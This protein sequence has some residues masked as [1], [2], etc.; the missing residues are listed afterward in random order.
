VLDLDQVT[1]ADLLPKAT[2][3]LHLAGD[4]VV[5]D[6][7]LEH[8]QPYRPRASGGPPGQTTMT[9]L[10]LTGVF[11]HRVKTHGS[12]QVKQPFSG[13]WIWRSPL[14]EYYLVDDTGTRRTTD[15]TRTDPGSAATTRATDGQPP[16]AA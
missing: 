4:T 16:E 3:Y 14:G 15:S 13:I 10:G 11:H 12:W 8:D 2:L 6:Q 7:H 1:V 5:R 9:N